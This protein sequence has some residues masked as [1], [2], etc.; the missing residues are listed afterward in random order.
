MSTTKTVKIPPHTDR[1]AFAYGYLSGCM[2]NVEYAMQQMRLRDD[3]EWKA[4]WACE[5][6]REITSFKAIDDALHNEH[7]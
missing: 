7:D 3:P 1:Y 6:Q 5:V 4:L 2:R